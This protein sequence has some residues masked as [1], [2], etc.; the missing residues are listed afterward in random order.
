[1]MIITDSNTKTL[2]MFDPPSLRD[3]LREEEYVHSAT[4]R[5]G[6]CL[7]VRC[8]SLLAICSYTSGQSCTSFDSP[9]YLSREHFTRHRCKKEPEPA[10]EGEKEGEE[11]AA[12]EEDEEEA[13]D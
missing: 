13:E 6:F 3:S 12:A 7:D 8:L 11:E 9:C 1:M 5:D 4:I 2:E 10:A